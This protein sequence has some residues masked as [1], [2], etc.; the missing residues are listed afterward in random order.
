MPGP[1]HGGPKGLQ[2]SSLQ[3]SR[4]AQQ[5]TLTTGADGART[6][7]G[8]GVGSNVQSECF[9]PRDRLA[10]TGIRPTWV[11]P[12]AHSPLGAACHL[13]EGMTRDSVFVMRPLGGSCSVNMSRVEVSASG[14]SP[15]GAGCSPGVGTLCW[16]GKGTARRGLLLACMGWQVPACGHGRT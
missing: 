12:P 1:T 6:G 7:T 16:E 4:W 2:P 5:A 10:M 11:P 8:C 13:L 15:G 3:P 9:S 14:L